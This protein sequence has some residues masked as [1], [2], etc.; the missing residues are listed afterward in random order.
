MYRQTHGAAERPF[1]SLMA[2]EKGASPL[3]TSPAVFAWRWKPP[4]SVHRGL[5]N[6]STAYH[7]KTTLSCVV[8]C[9][10][11]NNMCSVSPE[12]LEQNLRNV[13]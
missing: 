13:T 9:I 3:E 12:T 1:M 6:S 4:V 5:L 11:M 2:E 7:L 8:S 10:I